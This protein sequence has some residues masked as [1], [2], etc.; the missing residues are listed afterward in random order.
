MA[1]D[2]YCLDSSVLVKFL[3]SEEPVGL[4]DAAT[5]VVTRAVTNGHIVA[6]SFA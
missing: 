6:P 1:D 2:V 4:R 5:T 3:T